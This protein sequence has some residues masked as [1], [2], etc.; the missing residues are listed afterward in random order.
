[1]MQR[2]HRLTIYIHTQVLNDVIGHR[3]FIVY[4]YLRSTFLIE[5]PLNYFCSQSHAL[6]PR[7]ARRHNFPSN[8]Y[9]RFHA[10]PSESNQLTESIYLVK[11]IVMKRLL[12]IFTLFSI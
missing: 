6:R 12:H 7:F 9:Y 3:H 11:V 1:M 2:S 4:L 10:F 8:P 5:L